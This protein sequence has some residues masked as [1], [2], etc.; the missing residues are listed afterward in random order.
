MDTSAAQAL[1]VECASHWIRFTLI[2]L[3]GPLIFDHHDSVHGDV[4]THTDFISAPALK[5]EERPTRTDAT[6]L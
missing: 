4:T 3:L 1:Y 5:K 2:T 6:G